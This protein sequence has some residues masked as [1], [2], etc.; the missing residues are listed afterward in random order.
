MQA[1][2]NKV[3]QTAELSQGESDGSVKSDGEQ[4]EV[5]EVLL[6]RKGSDPTVYKRHDGHP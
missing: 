4:R 2:N 6:E 1:W 3:G 5:E